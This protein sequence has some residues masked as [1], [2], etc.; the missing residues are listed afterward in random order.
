MQQQL[1]SNLWLS[2]IQTRKL[3]FGW[4]PRKSPKAGK[5]G[6]SMFFDGNISH[7]LETSV[8]SLAVFK[9]NCLSYW[10]HLLFPFLDPSLNILFSVISSFEVLKLY[11][12]PRIDLINKLHL[13]SIASLSELPGALY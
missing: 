13:V 8:I 6:S 2:G 7:S 3:V 5:Q 9:E 4:G 12:S 11:A 1:Q 10:F